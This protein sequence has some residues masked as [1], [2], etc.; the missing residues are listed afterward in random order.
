MYA[1]VL[2]ATIRWHEQ[3]G[4]LFAFLIGL[5]LGLTTIARPTE[6]VMLFIPLLWNTQ[7]KESRRKKWK[8]LFQNRG[9]SAI[10]TALGGLIGVLPQLAYW[11]VVTGKW[12][13]DV[14]SKFT[15]FRPHWQVLIGWEKGWFIYTPIAIFMVIGLFLM[16]G[17]PFKRSVLTYFIINTWIIIAWADWRYGG[18]YSCRAL[19]QSYPVM[20]LPLALLVERLLATRMKWLTLGVGA[21]L[22]AVNLF[23][24]WQYNKTIIHYNDNNGPYYRAVYL[25]AH[26]TPLDMSLMDTP[27]ILRDESSYRLKNTVQFDTMQ[28]INA[29]TQAKV[30][31]WE[32]DLATLPGY[33]SDTDGWLRITARVKSDFG[34][35]ESSLTTQLT[36]GGKVKQTDCRLQNGICKDGEWNTIEY[37]F[38]IPATSSGKVVLY[39]ETKASQD[40]YL[41]DV[42]IRLFQQH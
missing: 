12:V 35:Y 17:R 9:E 27:E 19:A 34:A 3:P 31:F 6:V 32:Q 13:Y 1:L 14:G 23:Q 24:L 22:I 25:N 38:R 30:V 40:I 36:T 41:K 39:A 42:A 5:I 8:T 33:A 16:K 11:K 29:P 28:K 21:Y 37:Y 7:N 2:Y 10:L 20:A 4:R 15:F 26:P 18:S